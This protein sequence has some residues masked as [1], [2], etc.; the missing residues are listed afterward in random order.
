MPATLISERLTTS[1]ITS[2]NG[3]S[4]SGNLY[5]CGR[6]TGSQTPTLY[7]VPI[8][9]NVLGTA[10]AGPALATGTPDCSPV[11]EFLNGSTDYIFLSVDANRQPSGCPGHRLHHVVQRDQRQRLEREHSTLRHLAGIPGAQAGSSSTT[12]PAPLGLPRSTSPAFYPNL[13]G[14]WQHRKRHGRLRRAGV[15]D[16]FTLVPFQLIRAR[17]FRLRKYLIFRVLLR[18]SGATPFVGQRFREQPALRSAGLRSAVLREMPEAQAPDV[19]KQVSP[20]GSM[21]RP[22]S[23]CNMFPN[24]R[25]S[26]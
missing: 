11:T 21:C 25:L 18:R 9:S 10:V 12:A 16:G 8:T 4:P 14:K 13:H 2:S 20:A 3:A 24:L 7:Q 15:T 23:R 17:A 1:T 19:G 26:S 22:V 5:V 6:A